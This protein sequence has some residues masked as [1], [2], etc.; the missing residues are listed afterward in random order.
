[1]DFH[2][3]PGTGTWPTDEQ[4][5]ATGSRRNINSDI[6]SK[7]FGW[8]SNQGFMQFYIYQHK[9]LNSYS[10]I[11]SIL[12]SFG[13]VP[14]DIYQAAPT[15]RTFQSA[16][17]R[18]I[19]HDCIVLVNRQLLIPESGVSIWNVSDRVKMAHWWCPVE[20]Q[21]L[22]CTNNVSMTADVM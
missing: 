4:Y 10:H 18:F 6:N 3:T 8:V 2:C 9:K 19:H 22:K 12:R 14:A 21:E 5:R 17:Q 16:W 13:W 15:S 7:M 1:M 20:I 11:W